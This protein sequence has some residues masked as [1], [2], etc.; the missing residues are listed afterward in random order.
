MDTKNQLSIQPIFSMPPLATLPQDLLIGSPKELLP[1]LKT[2]DNVDLVG[3]SELLEVLKEDISFLETPWPL[4]LNNK[5]L[6][7]I[8]KI[9]VV[10]ELISPQ[11]TTMLTELDY[12]PKNPILTNLEVVL[13]DLV[14]SPLIRFTSKP[15]KF[16]D[17]PLEPTTE[18]ISSPL[19]INNHFPS[20]SKP[21]PVFSNPTLV[22][23]SPQDVELP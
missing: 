4:S 11:L 20:V 17:K 7:V 2:K 19:L 9:V 3:L 13:Q 21:T 22:V 6:L 16:L 12:V 10:E 5:S 18:T 14:K 1:Q 8:I 23:S 15:V